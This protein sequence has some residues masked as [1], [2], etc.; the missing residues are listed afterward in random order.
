MKISQ[1]LPKSPPKKF[2]SRNFNRFLSKNYIRMEG[3]C[4]TMSNKKENIGLNPGDVRKLVW[5]MVA[6]ALVVC[7][8]MYVLRMGGWI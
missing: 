5:K 8:I 3:D 1:V 6:V 4:K 2:C 7:G